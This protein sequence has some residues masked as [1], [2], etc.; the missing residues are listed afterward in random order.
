MAESSKRGWSCVSD[1]LLRIFFGFRA[2]DF[3]FDA[4]ASDFGFDL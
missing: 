1:F 4:C 3:G 2:S